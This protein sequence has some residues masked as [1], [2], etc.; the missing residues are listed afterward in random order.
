MSFV[1]MSKHR[2]LFDLHVS[3]SAIS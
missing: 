2:L 3:A 1:D